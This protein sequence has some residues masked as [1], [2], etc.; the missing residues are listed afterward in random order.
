MIDEAARFRQ[1]VS[2]NVEALGSDADLQAFSRVWLR[3]VAPYKYAYN[4][5]WLG[6]PVIQLPQ[7]M[8][9][10]QEIIWS[11]RPDV[12]IETGV[13]HGGSLIYYA[14]LLHLLGG[15]GYVI[16]VDIEIRPHNRVQIESHSL[17]PR[18][19]LVE[20]SSIDPAIV[21]RVAE[22]AHGKRA[23]VILDSNH[24]HDHV[25][26][27]LRL[28]SPFVSMGSYLVVF[29]TAIEDMPENAYPNRPWGRGNNPKTAV[30]QFLQENDR[31]VIDRHIES[32]LLITVAPGGYLSCVRD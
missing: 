21:K 25:I 20:G 32:K 18:I 19:K 2:A 22:L 3:A 23:V 26:Q 5:T 16:G 29:D 31:F 27:E 11:V 15:A 7:D 24:T 9:A 30:R 4:F 8:L 6:R 14:S 1:E 13:A 12:V 17:A 10:T 28:Y